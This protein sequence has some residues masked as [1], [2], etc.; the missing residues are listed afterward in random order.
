M[1]R[2]VMLDKIRRR[3]V[4]PL[5]DAQFGNAPLMRLVIAELTR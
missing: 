5:D 4:V 3:T 1:H 2:G